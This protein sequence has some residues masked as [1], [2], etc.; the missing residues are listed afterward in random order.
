[1]IGPIAV[2]GIWG[3]IKPLQATVGWLLNSVAEAVLMGIVSLAALVPLVPALFLAADLGGI[4]AVAWVMVGQVLVSLL[5]LGYFAARRADAPLRGQVRAIAPALIA[6]LG[7]WL[8]ARGAVE[9]LSAELP[10]V[11][12]IGGLAA[13]LAAYALILELVERGILRTAL[14]Q[15]GRTLGRGPE[16]PDRE[17]RVVAAP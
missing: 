13:G 4:T 5:A 2:L 15:I 7:A 12:L 1:M 9:L 3:A 16:S 10:L 8:A 6:C 14:G 11:A 17:E